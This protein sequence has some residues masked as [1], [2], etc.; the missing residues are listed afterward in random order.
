MHLLQSTFVNKVAH[1]RLAL[2]AKMKIFGPNI[3]QERVATMVLG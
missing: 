3:E 1:T 2:L